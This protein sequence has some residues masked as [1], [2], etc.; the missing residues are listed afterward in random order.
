MFDDTGGEPIRWCPSPS[1][2]H[3]GRQ[4]ADPRRTFRSPPAPWSRSARSAGSWRW[5]A[6]PKAL[7]TRCGKTYGVTC[8]Y[9]GFMYEYTFF[10][11][12]LAFFKVCF[13][14]LESSWWRGNYLNAIKLKHCKTNGPP[15]GTTLNSGECFHRYAPTISHFHHFTGLMRTYISY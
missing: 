12:M 4:G 13:L 5:Q 15:Q 7:P 1:H 9:H 3:C 14:C 6:L 10:S 11:L 2:S 8:C